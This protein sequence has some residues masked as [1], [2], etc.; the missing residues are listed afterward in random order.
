M[1]TCH[2]CGRPHVAANKRFCQHCG[3][4]VNRSV[5]IPTP[6]GWSPGPP[7]PSGR[8]NRTPTGPL[9]VGGV[10]L[11]AILI[12]T[13][14]LVFALDRP[15]ATRGT[16]ITSSDPGGSANSG[17]GQVPVPP[18]PLVSTPDFTTDQP[19]PNTSADDPAT[20]VANYYTAV[21]NRD[22]QTAWQLGGENLHETYTAFVG[23]YAT[24]VSDVLNVVDTTGDTVDVD[25][26]A[27]WTDGTTHEFQGSYTVVNGQIVSGTLHKIS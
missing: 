5:D 22:Y 14:V 12:V 10:I 19:T 21:D 20:V 16:A 24:T 1:S 3:T 27:Q 17:I 11:A 13:V 26:V 9:I 6:T 2:K 18:P 15:G 25:L 8:S 23:G 7:R 4:P